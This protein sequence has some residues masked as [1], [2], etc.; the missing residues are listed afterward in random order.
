MELLREEYK[1]AA[2]RDGGAGHIKDM[3]MISERRPGSRTGRC[4]A[5]GKAT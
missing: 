4:P 5:T 2:A 3:V 1:G